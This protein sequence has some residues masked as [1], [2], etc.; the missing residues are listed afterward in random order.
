MLI[1][2]V[3]FLKTPQT[4]NRYYTIFL[5]DSPRP[6]TRTMFKEPKSS[7]NSAIPGLVCDAS[8]GINISKQKTG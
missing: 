1:E 5:H 6:I 7:I 2:R 4:K 8:T 3:Q